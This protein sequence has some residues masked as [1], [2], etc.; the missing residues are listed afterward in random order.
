MHNVKST[1]E[2]FRLL[3]TQGGAITLDGVS[4]DKCDKSTKADC[5]ALYKFWNFNEFNR[6]RLNEIVT[7]YNDT[8]KI[9]DNPLIRQNLQYFTNLNVGGK[10][11][12]GSLVNLGYMMTG[13]END[14][15]SDALAISIEIF[16]TAILLHDDVLDHALKRRGKDTVPVQFMRDYPIIDEIM[17]NHPEF[18]NDMANGVAISLG[19]I[20]LYLAYEKMVEAYKDNPN[21]PEVLR[22]YND[23]MLKTIQGGMMDMISPYKE[24]YVKPEDVE[25]EPDIM[26]TVVDIGYL[27]TA[28]YTT[29]G[30][31]ILGMVLNGS[32]PS[33]IEEMNS[34][35]KDVGIAFQIQDDILGVFA[36]AA[37]LGKDVGADVAEYKQTFL[38][39]YVK[40]NCPK[41]YTELIKYYGKENITEEELE[42]VR[43]IF[44]KSGAYKF[45]FDKME[46]YYN[47]AK[48]KL[49]KADFI[50]DEYKEMLMG[51]II[52][53][54]CREY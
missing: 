7:A 24:R 54:E 15:Y 3:K 45:T 37:V 4:F 2:L 26:K 8:L 44:N 35:M 20:G 33:Q 48:E 29:M 6:T 17:D 50:S 34:M 36:D 22:T 47:S 13:G 51:F 19:Y 21:F 9:S 53:L 39:A 46:H 27:K 25:N 38:Y 11:L 43:K 40:E 49:Q 23:I 14:G 42:I 30:P 5:E 41:D 18:A 16:Q 32:A 10:M 31:L 1:Q 12:R 52:Y 28:C